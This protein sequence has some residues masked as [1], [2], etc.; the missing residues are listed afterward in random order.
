[1]LLILFISNRS[2]IPDKSIISTGLE[3]GSPEMDS[4]TRIQILRDAAGAKISQCTKLFTGAN[5]STKSFSKN[6]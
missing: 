5:A 2:Y 1:L 4:E 3:R 6:L